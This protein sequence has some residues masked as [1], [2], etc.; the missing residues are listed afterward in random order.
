MTESLWRG[1]EEPVLS[2][3]EGTSAML[4]NRCSSELSGHQNHERNQK[5]TTSRDDK[6][7]GDGSIESGCWTEAFFI[8]LGGPAANEHSDRK[9]SPGRVRGTQIPRDDI[10][11][12]GKRGR[13]LKPK[14][15]L[16]WATQNIGRWCSE[17]C[18]LFSS[19][20][21]GRLCSIKCLVSTKGSTS[22]SDSIE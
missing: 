19:Q 17:L 7:K 15:R 5:V 16:E 10:G 1:V 12:L 11:S 18:L 2:E 21:K 9:T 14:R 13:P 8:T 3:A 4:V 20:I 6:G 22:E